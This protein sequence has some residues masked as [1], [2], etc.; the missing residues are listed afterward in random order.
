MQY[1]FLKNLKSNKV[2]FEEF[3]TRIEKLQFSNQK[4]GGKAGSF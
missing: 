4:E 2:L 1:N 3:A